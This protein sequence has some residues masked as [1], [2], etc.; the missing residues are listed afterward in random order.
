MVIIDLDQ[1]EEASGEQTVIA[2]GN[3][4]G[5]HL[6]HRQLIQTAQNV[7]AS[8]SAQSAVLLFKNHTTALFAP[9]NARCLTSVED[10][11]AML[12]A[13]GLDLV[14]LHTFD[15]AFASLDPSF[16]LDEMLIRRMG[17]I[18][19]V[20]GRDYRFGRLAKGSVEDLKRAEEAQKIGLSIVSDVKYQGERI[21]STRIRQAIMD[22]K[23]EAAR[24]MLGGAYTLRGFVD[25]GAQRGHGLGF[26]TANLSMSFPY[27]LPREGVYLTR[28][29]I[30]G[31]KGTFYG[32]S[33]VGTN[34]TFHEH[35]GVSVET[36]LFDFH[37]PIYGL[38]FSVSFL[39]YER[40]N[41]AFASP[42]EL[43]EQMNQDLHL[44]RQWA[45]EERVSLH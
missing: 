18:H 4:D 17:A 8:Q 41:V 15:E 5:L 10:K 31:K 23:P 14:Y 28:S 42:Q 43:S 36:H 45:Q 38:G 13:M 1:K 7:A 3:F 30:E 11:L 25:H 33:S 2:L 37:E 22:G 44:L 16:F 21:S 24:A 27:V 12:E 34:P 6:G 35:R 40:P 39:R 29:E 32:M 19:V 9:K 20:V 26:A